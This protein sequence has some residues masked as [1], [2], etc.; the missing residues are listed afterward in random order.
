MGYISITRDI[1]NERNNTDVM[2]LIED[3]CLAGG[4]VLR[5]IVFRIMQSHAVVEEEHGSQIS[6][7]CSIT[8]YWKP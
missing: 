4:V 7:T 5:Q 8:S 6:Q 2:V 1:L 3:T